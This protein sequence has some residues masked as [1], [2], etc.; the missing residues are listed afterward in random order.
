MR[1]VAVIADL[2]MAII[3][4]EAARE[5]AAPEAYLVGAPCLAGQDVRT[6]RSMGALAAECRA[7]TRGLLRPACQSLADRGAQAGRP[8][9]PTFRLQSEAA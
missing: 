4:R 2:P 5:R 7:L 3:D 6:W 8:D 9:E 1:K